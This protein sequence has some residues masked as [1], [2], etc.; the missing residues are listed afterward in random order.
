MAPDIF[1]ISPKMGS[2]LGPPFFHFR[3]LGSQKGGPRRIGG[4]LLAPREAPE[5]QKTPEAHV[6]SIQGIILF[7]ALTAKRRRPWTPQAAAGGDFDSFWCASRTSRGPKKGVRKMDRK[8]DPQKIDFWRLLDR[9]VVDPGGVCG[10][11]LGLKLTKS[12]SY[13]ARLAPRRGRRIQSLRALRQGRGISKKCK[14][15]RTISLETQR[16]LD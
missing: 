15:H 12:T 7:S 16:K 5:A 4:H 14:I 6:D 13:S 8:R 10:W 3:A 2:I 11:H 1:D 9:D